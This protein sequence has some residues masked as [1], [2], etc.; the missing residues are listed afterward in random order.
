MRVTLY[1]RPYRVRYTSRRLFARRAPAK[2]WTYCDA[3]VDHDR[4][5]ILIGGR[6]EEGRRLTARELVQRTAEVVADVAAEIRAAAEAR[7]VT[8]E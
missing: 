3:H 5:E 2:E 8:E 4:R 1:G 7:P 6:N